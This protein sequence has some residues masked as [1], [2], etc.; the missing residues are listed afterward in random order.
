M[1]PDCDD[2]ERFCEESEI[3]KVRRQISFAGEGDK[4]L[5]FLL[6]SGSFNPIHTQHVRALELS[7]R[8]L[9]TLG[10]A[11]VGAF[12][13]PSSATQ[14]QEKLGAEGFLLAER[15][16]LC[17]LAVAELDWVSV[18]VKGEFSSNWACRG[19]RNEIEQG[20]VDVLNGR[21]LTGVEVMGSDTV[22]RI[23]EKV[24]Q[25]HSRQEDV[26]T[27]RG[28]TVCCLL[29]RGPQ[30]AEQK[31]HIETVLVARMSGLGVELL[32][33]DATTSDPPLEQVSSSAIRELVARDKWDVLQSHGWLSPRVLQ[34]LRARQ[35][36]L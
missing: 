19:V 20:C 8:H 14:V 3:V 9:E 6:L 12:L 36:D 23:F 2:E 24:L 33:L 31:Q 29:R 5:A 15:I 32:V 4:K 17:R 22:V 21:Q 35:R 7:R 1:T 18:C 27:Q 10:Y 26:S 16:A 34:A 28:R 13:A 30:H 25:K 11:V